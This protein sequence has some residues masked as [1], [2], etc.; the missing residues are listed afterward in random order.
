MQKNYSLYH[1]LGYWFILLGILAFIAFYASYISV[2]F[3]STIPVFHI[4]F[5]LM[6]LWILMLI[7]Q[8]FLI[9]YKKIS[10]HRLL[11]KISYVLVP[12]VLLSAFLVIRFSYYRD[13]DQLHKDVTQGLSHFSESQILQQVAEWKG[14]PFI[15]FFWFILFYSLAVINRRKSAVHARFMLATALSLLGP[16]IDRIVFKIGNLTEHIRFELIAFLIADV[17]LSILLWNDYI[18]KRPTKTLRNALLIYTIG[19]ALY[20]TIPGT[21]A[22]KYFVTFVMKPNS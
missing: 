3:Q 20:F 12:L 1:N 21:N 19:Q 6:S 7:A 8:P 5:T 14:L 15:W 13:L 2:I 16:I 10:A 17:V 18:K 4:H 22:W 11:G 9:K